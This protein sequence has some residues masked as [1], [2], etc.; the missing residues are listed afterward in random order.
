MKSKSKVY[1]NFMR[2]SKSKLVFKIL[3]KVYFNF[4]RESKSK[5]V[6]KFQICLCNGVSSHISWSWVATLRSRPRTY[7]RYELTRVEDLQSI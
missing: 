6:L 5:L 2:E 1:F 7:T 4:G 3:K